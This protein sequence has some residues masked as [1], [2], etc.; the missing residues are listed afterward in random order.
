MWGVVIRTIGPRRSGKPL[1]CDDRRDFCAPAAQSGFSSMVKRPPRRADFGQNPARVE[2]DQ[3]ADGRRPSHRSRSRPNAGQLRALAGPSPRASATYNP[4]LFAPR[5]RFQAVRRILHPAPR[6]LIP[7][8]TVA[9]KN[10]TGSGS[11]IA[12]AKSPLTSAGDDGATTFN[13]GIAIA[14]FSIACDACAP[15]CRPPP[16]ALRS[17]IGKITCPSVV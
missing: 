8:S 17:T 4:I 9:S 7:R 10:I 11:R 3:A 16:F 12:A 1:I 15:C 2:R 5:L 13:P 14:Q 6:S